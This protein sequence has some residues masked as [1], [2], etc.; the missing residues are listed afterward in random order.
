MSILYL[1]LLQTVLAFEIE[2]IRE[3]HRPGLPQPS[4][5]TSLMKSQEDLNLKNYRGII[6]TSN[7][8]LGTPS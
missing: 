4:I 6:Y 5:F 1:L 7:I 2:L 8:Y 3:N